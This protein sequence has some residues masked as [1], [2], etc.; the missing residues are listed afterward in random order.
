M[1]ILLSFSCLCLRK[2]ISHPNYYKKGVRSL[3]GS[4]LRSAQGM[5][6]VRI[7]P[8]TEYRMYPRIMQSQHMRETL[9]CDWIK[10]TAEREEITVNNKS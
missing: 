4:A 7:K 10:L 2:E 9:N 5:G 1:K 3:S 8:H 6:I